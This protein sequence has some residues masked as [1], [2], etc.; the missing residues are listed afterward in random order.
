MD[1]KKITI[2]TAFFELQLYWRTKTVETNL[3]VIAVCILM[4][5]F[6]GH[7]NVSTLAVTILLLDILAIVILSLPGAFVKSEPYT[8]EDSVVEKSTAAKSTYTDKAVIDGNQVDASKVVKEVDGNINARVQTKVNKVDQ[9]RT[10]LD[11]ISQPPT[12][13]VSTP[14]GNKLLD[15]MPDP[16]TAS[17]DSEDFD[18]LFDI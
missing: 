16:I 17:Q 11:K 9:P 5:I 13:D 14:T 12:V 7:S 18:N 8:Q 1:K 10:V 3:V 6:G 2:H 4:Y 15:K